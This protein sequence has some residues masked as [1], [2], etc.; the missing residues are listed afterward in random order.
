LYYFINDDAT[1]HTKKYIAANID[2]VSVSADAIFF[3][4]IDVCIARIIH[5]HKLALILA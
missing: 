5:T 3:S 1:L 4:L 2:V